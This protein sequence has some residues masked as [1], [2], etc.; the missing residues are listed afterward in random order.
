MKKCTECGNFDIC[1]DMVNSA[2]KLPEIYDN[3]EICWRP[4]GA[5][6]TILEEEV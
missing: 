5:V 2:V 4:P 6:I 1:W 3:Q